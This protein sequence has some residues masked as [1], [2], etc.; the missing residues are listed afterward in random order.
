MLLSQLY[1]PLLKETPADAE[2]T[3]H[4]LMMR[5]GLIRKIA[6]GCY[7][8]LPLGLRVLHKV[9]AIIREEMLAVGAQECLM[10]VLQ[11]AELW[12]E[13]GRWDQY[14]KELM[15]LEDRHGRHFSLGPTHEEVMV[16]LVRGELKSYKQLPVTFYQIQTKFRDEIRPR[17]GVMRGREFL[18]KDAYSFHMDQAS[19][20]STY[21]AMYQAYNNIF[22]RL[23]LRY[24][25]VLADSGSIGGELS[26]EFQVL[27]QSGEDIVVYSDGSDYAANLE[28]AT[29]LVS[30]DRSKPSETLQKFA[31]PDAKTIED[32]TTQY[33]IQPVQTV[34][35]LLVVGE[36][37]PMVALVLRGDHTLNVL[38]AEKLADVKAPL[39]M[40]DEAQV[41]A[42]LG[43]GVGSLGPVKLSVPIIVDHAAANLADFVCG[44]NEDGFHYRGANWEVDVALGAAA[45]LRHVCEGDVSPDGQGQLQFA[46]GI[47]VGHIFQLGDIYTKALSMTVLSDA[48][49]AVAPVMGCYG[50]GV[51]RVVAAAIEQNHDARGICWPAPMAP[52]QVAILPLNMHKSYR[53]KAFAES[54]YQHYLSQGIEV[55]MDDRKE[56]PGVMFSTADLMGVPHR[57]VIGERGLDEDT[58]EYKRRDSD[59]VEHITLDAA[60]ALLGHVPKP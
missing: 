1:L 12:E 20:Q 10:P 26:H 54:L 39:E 17:F 30:Q 47:E 9:E 60:K 36:A 51:S 58:V 14:G 50:I 37:S 35:T 2:L 38:K 44:A 3:S 43:V 46:R 41:K 53:V 27:A 33:D 48:G 7:S 6:S 31:T 8:W 23:G 59:E 24:R 55:V 34:K 21:D 57:I 29:A 56:R 49:K 16:D 22:T 4:Q 28:R 5:A 45:D 19:L 52:Y 18:M 13:S 11:P 40:V 42:A 15:R 32:L 25:A